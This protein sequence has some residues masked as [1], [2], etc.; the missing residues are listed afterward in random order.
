[1]TQQRREYLFF[2][3]FEYA[4]I[5]E[6]LQPRAFVAENVAGL[7]RG[8]AKGYFKLILK[9]LKD[10]GYNVRAA[11]LDASWLGVPQSRRRLIFIGFRD[12]LGIAPQFPKPLP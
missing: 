11:V 3:F 12:D 9:R 7:V 5:L 1:M 4:R 6:G 2:L 10:C 8:K